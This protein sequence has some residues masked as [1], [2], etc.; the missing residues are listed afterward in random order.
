MNASGSDSAWPRAHGDPVAQAVMRQSPE[1]FSVEELDAF[2]PSGQGEH[3]LLSVQ[4]TG[5]N[6]MAAARVIADWAGVAESA[7]GYA[8]LKDRHAIATQRFSVWLP[9]RIAPPIERLQTPQLRVLQ[10]DW[11]ARK[12]PR[13]ALAGNRFT[14][15]LRSVQGEPERIEAR[16]RTIAQC[17]VPNYF[18]E[19]RFGRDGGNVDKALAM[20]SGRRV[21]REERGLLLSA[22]RSQL[23]NLALAARVHESNWNTA[24]EGDV[25]ML[26]GSRSVFGP[27]PLDALL[28]QRVAQCDIHPAGPLWGR[29]ELRT[30]QRARQIEQAALDDAVSMRLRLGLEHAGLAQERRALR[31]SVTGL[32]WHWL[33]EQTLRLSFELPPG[34][35]ATAVL[36][37]LGEMQ[38]L[39]PG[40]DSSRD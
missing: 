36:A 3:L 32:Q 16:L 28:I 23:F 21:K 25:F 30:Q 2:A 18:G 29:G 40:S 31:L 33:P 22:A 17:G 27:E 19:Q 8:G 20:F 4:K 10:A 15:S 11:H 26:E 39:A 24:I 13:G 37:E 14:I 7:I 35:Y 9:K 6:T 1:D 5:M 34:C 12:L 38:T